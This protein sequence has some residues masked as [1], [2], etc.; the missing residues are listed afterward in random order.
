[1]FTAIEGRSQSLDL[2]THNIGLGIIRAVVDLFEDVIQKE[3]TN[4]ITM[5]KSAETP[6][7][8]NVAVNNADIVNSLGDIS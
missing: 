4:S 5:K 7:V 6:A 1:M 8:E 3:L 2:A